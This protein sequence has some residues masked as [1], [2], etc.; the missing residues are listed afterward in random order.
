MLSILDFTKASSCQQ[1]YS[2]KTNIRLL[3]ILKRKRNTATAIFNKEG[4]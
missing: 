1:V 3:K 4:V 2:K